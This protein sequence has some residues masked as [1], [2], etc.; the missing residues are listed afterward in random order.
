MGASGLQNYKEC[1][2]GKGSDYFCVRAL[3][4]DRG[5]CCYYMVFRNMPAE[6]TP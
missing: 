3:G 2:G 1:E 4:G 5:A 6:P